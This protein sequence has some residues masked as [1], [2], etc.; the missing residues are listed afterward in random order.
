M[1][2]KIIYFIILITFINSYAYEIIDLDSYKYAYYAKDLNQIKDNIVIYKFKPNKETKKIF[3]LFLGNS[4][5]GSFEFY[6]Y[7]ELSDIQCD[8]NNNF[9]NYLEKFINYGEKK[10]NQELDVYYILVRMN[11]YEDKYEYVSFMIYNS[12]EYWDIGNFQ[13]NDEYILAFEKDNKI[14]LNYSAK[15]TTQYLYIYR[16][17]DC[18][19]ISYALY[20]N[21]SAQELVEKITDNCFENKY[22]ILTLLRNTS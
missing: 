17:G 4:N 5:D 22:H 7:K 3:L 11:S 20:K 18:D 21:N 14:I 9:I 8:D 6:L 12:E 13:Q 19:E 2:K 10:I 16:K 1:K 15:N